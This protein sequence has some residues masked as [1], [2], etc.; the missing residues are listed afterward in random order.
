[1]IRL[2]EADEVRVSRNMVGLLYMAAL[3]GLK[4]LAANGLP[5]PPALVDAVAAAGLFLEA[6][7]PVSDP[8]QERAGGE[9]MCAVSERMTATAAATRVGV[10]SRT[11]TRWAQSGRLPTANQAHPGSPWIIDVREALEV[12]RG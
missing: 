10:T 5:P 6:T 12:A 3:P 11:L 7:A 1:V 8:G 2:P 9:D 4:Y